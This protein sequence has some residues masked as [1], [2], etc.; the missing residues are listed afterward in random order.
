MKQLT[1]G[2]AIVT[3]GSRGLGPV[4]AR[5]LAREGMDVVVAA[6]S[7]KELA[8]VAGALR[9]EGTRVTPIT[10]DVSDPA[11]REALIARTMELHGRLD[12]LVNNAGLAAVSRLHEMAP[13]QIDRLIDVNLRAAMQLTRA[14]LPPLLAARRGHIVNIASVSGRIAA[15]YLS[16]YSATK[17]G[18]VGFTRALRH[19]L[20]GSG[21]GASVIAPGFVSGV[22]MY[23]DALAGIVDAPRRPGTVTSGQVARAV[24]RA[25]R[26][27]LPDVI[28][29]SRGTRV[30]LVTD[31]AFPRVADRV[32]GWLGV[33]AVLRRAADARPPSRS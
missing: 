22:G 9:A 32:L 17:F 30:L 25:V 24:L 15:P 11:D 18:L 20:R 4:I 12:L 14:A 5:A 33:P 10:C 31:A 28:V 6:R 23:V 16:A 29:G 19:E 21:V 26:G 27:D 1:G 3:G 2:T 7:G 8:A 13:D